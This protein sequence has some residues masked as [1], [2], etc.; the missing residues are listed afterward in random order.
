MTRILLIEG[1][2]FAHQAMSRAQGTRTGSEVYA[3]TIT[4]HVPDIHIDTFHAAEPGQSL[5]DGMALAAYDGM[6]IGGSALHAYDTDFSVTN[7]IE[8]A[9]AFGETGKPILGSCWGLQVSV[10][11]AGGAVRKS[12]NGREIGFAKQV[13]LTEAGRVHPMFAGKPH[14]FDAPC[15]HYDEIE[16]LPEGARVL[17]A[18]AHS[19]VQAATF[20]L[21]RSTVC[22]V[23]YHPEFDLPHLHRVMTR[24]TDAMIDEGIFDSH[25]A[26]DT[27]LTH[28]TQTDDNPLGLGS[29][30]TDDTIR[31]AEIINWVRGV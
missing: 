6:I 17:A 2:T 8:I 30:I 9:R 11:A 5:P 22:A 4:A 12:P 14:A 10:I 21:G 31:R 16:T 15:I 18:N 1:N 25:A 7:Q 28:M 19:P 27:F 13:T 23:Q 20:T 3:E 29:D 24:N 26:A